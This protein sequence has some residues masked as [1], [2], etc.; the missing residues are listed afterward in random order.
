[1]IFEF[2]N[3]KF[4]K[5]Q[6]LQALNEL[7]INS[8][9][10]ICVHSELFKLGKIL[11]SKD[12]FLTSISSTLCASVRADDNQ[13]TILIPTFTYN[14]CKSSV[15]DK[16][17]SAC[18]VGVLGEY[19]R[20]TKNVWRSN[21]PIFNYVILGRDTNKYKI[22][23]KSCF[24]ANSLFDVM[25]KN[26][27]KI[28]VFGTSNT[29]CTLIHH[30]EEYMQVP[31][32]CYKAFNGVMIDEN[33]MEREC[34]INYFVRRLDMKSTINIPKMKETLLKE[35]VL[36]ILPFAGGELCM[37]PYKDCFE[38]MLKYLQKDPYYFVND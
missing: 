16:N 4:G 12:D 15:Y 21:D 13:G 30:A 3:T 27:A 8:G 28:I 26:N 34:S 25:L 14:F 36:K 37:M 6:I 7:Q 17:N 11:T 31:Y 24:G 32:R 33:G 10:T 9:D 35:Q 20:K 19:F 23:S 18:E 22:V 1:M 2:N 38:V 5:M 29:G